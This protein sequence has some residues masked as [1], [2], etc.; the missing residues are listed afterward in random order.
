VDERL[1]RLTHRETAEL[2]E[3]MRAA[4]RPGRYWRWEQ[5]E[6]E[7]GERAA[8]V[9][10]P[11]GELVNPRIAGFVW[12][13]AMLRCITTA[14]I[15]SGDHFNAQGLEGKIRVRTTLAT[16]LLVYAELPPHRC[17]VLVGPSPGDTIPAGDIIPA[18]DSRREKVGRQS[19]S[20]GSRDAAP[21]AAGVDCLAL[22]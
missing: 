22:A 3:Q 8:Q 21:L 9:E 5:W 18:R 7:Y 1:K 15:Q 17:Q 14:P 20:T 11:L 4:A 16:A 10:F 6:W 2:L 12:A 13:W 19:D